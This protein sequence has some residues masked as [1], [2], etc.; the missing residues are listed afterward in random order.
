MS[1]LADIAHGIVEVVF[2]E[3]FRQPERH[4]LETWRVVT[5][6]LEIR[7]LVALELLQESFIV[8][9]EQSNVGNV[10]QHHRQPLQ[11][12]S[13]RP[14]HFVRVT[15]V[16][17]NSLLNH[18][19]AEHF[20]PL[21]PKVDFQFQRW[22]REREIGADP[23]HL[24]IAKECSGQTWTSNCTQAGSRISNNYDDKNDAQ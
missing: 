7:W 13:K 1:Y 10:V 4:I 9:P 21:V 5:E 3:M 8:T 19:A 20:E 17:D 23:S 22:I 11:S 24:D 12:Q 6:R 16:I 15:T 14:T 18:P 2:V